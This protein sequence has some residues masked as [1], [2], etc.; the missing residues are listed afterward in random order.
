[1]I[2]YYTKL[3][4]EIKETF[5]D[6]KQRGLLSLLYDAKKN[7][8]I[9]IPTNKE[10]IEIVTELLKKTKTQVI[11]NPGLASHL[12][13]VN[14]FFKDEKVTEILVGI[15]GIE[16]GYKVRHSKE[17][18]VKAHNASWNFVKKG[19]FSII[20]ELKRVL[21]TDYMK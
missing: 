6:R 1:M 16:M 10:H 15:S 20:K 9:P 5:G 13:P 14:V 21:K 2:N 8:F 4:A 11:E 7:A 3:K 17:D 12:I 18:L 19:D